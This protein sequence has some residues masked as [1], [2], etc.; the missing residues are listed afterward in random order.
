M[1]HTRVLRDF[2]E[3]TCLMAIHFLTAKVG[4]A[5]CQ[6]E[7]ACLQR[8]SHTCH[9]LCSQAFFH[10]LS[11]DPGP[12]CSLMFSSLSPL[13]PLHKGSKCH[14]ST[15]QR[16]WESATTIDL[17]FCDQIIKCPSRRGA[18]SFSVLSPFSWPGS[19]P[20]VLR[21]RTWTKLWLQLW[22]S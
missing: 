17:I 15:N 8:H 14:H 13:G 1:N 4:P 19:E 18:I 11:G 16:A 9:L 5:V 7:A 21:E 10:R 22:L 20:E 12:G 6:R 2:Q 3:R